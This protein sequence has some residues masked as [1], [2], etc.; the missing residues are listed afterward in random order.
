MSLG[1]WKH[2]LNRILV[3]C[4]TPFSTHDMFGPTQ[5]LFCFTK[6]YA[7]FMLG[8]RLLSSSVAS[9]FAAARITSAITMV[10]ERETPH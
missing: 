1:N 9:G 2:E 8:P 3:K 5:A 10:A 4:M 7:A 6:S